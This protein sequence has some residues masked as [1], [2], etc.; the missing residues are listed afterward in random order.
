MPPGGPAGQ[1]Q[2]A[3]LPIFI[4]KGLLFHVDVAGLFGIGLSLGGPPWRGGAIWPS[5]PSMMASAIAPAMSFTAR[6]GVIV[7]GNDIVDFVGGR[8]WCPRWPQ[9][10]Y[11]GCGPRTRRCAPC[12][13][14][15]MNR[16]PG[17]G[18]HVLNA[19]QETLQLFNLQLQ[20][21]DFLLGQQVK[22]AV[23]LP[24]CAAGPGAGCGCGWW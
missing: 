14:S 7:A 5:R 23:P 2:S 3:F 11:P 21:A 22:G 1:I 20:L 17:V 10:E 15:T 4:E 12:G 6:M 24:S 16:A 9:S 13:G 8:S 18:L 19:A